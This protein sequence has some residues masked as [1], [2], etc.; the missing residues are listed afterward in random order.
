MRSRRPSILPIIRFSAWALISFCLLSLPA[1]AVTPERSLPNEGSPYHNFSGIGENQIVHIPTGIAVTRDQMID[2][3]AGS[4]VI[5]V[6]EAH[7]NLEAHRIQLEVIEN[8]YKRFPGKVALGMEMFRQSAQSELDLWHDGKLSNEKFTKVFRQNWGEGY[9]LY[10]PI[11]NYAKANGLPLIGLKSST[12]TEN[13]LRKGY[14]Q[15][16]FPELDENDIYHRKYAEAI[17]GGGQ[18][19][20][21]HNSGAMYKMLTLWDE[22]MAE[23]VA[24]FLKNP[25]YR[26]WKLIVLAGGFHVQYGYGI[27]KRSFRRVPHSYSIIIPVV[28][29]MPSELL[30]REMKIEP[31]SIPLY[32]AD[33]GWKISYKVLPK[34]RIRLGI[35]IKDETEKGVRVVSVA[36]GSLAEK[37]QLNDND[38][39]LSLD[40][41]EISGV[42]DLVDRLQT[43]HFGDQVEIRVLRDGREMNLSGII[44]KPDI[45]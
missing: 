26:D 45:D 30:D 18:K 37:M 1:H 32:A 41:E 25:E 31:V 42:D 39:L 20:H 28:K 17:F 6:G 15:V 12:E 22:S 2:T 11:F 5:Y 34:N 35:H 44:G 33:F 19:N 27:P 14:T 4:R 23:T 16:N 40:E 21:D 29:E 7:D 10:Q 24:T 9:K 36:K 8:I 38:L 13:R 3:V 43:K